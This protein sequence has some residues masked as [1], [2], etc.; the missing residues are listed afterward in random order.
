MTINVES[1]AHLIGSVGETLNLVGAYVL[2][3]DLLY[4][5]NEFEEHEKLEEVSR[6]LH[7]NSISLRLEKADLGS[8]GAAAL[9]VVRRA[10]QLGKRGLRWL[11]WGFAFLILYHVLSIIASSAH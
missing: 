6:W 4:R 5:Q 9:I 2:A 11:K 1:I 10:V 7:T 8:P 3:R